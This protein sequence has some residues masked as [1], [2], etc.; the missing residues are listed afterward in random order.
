[1]LILLQGLS[2][3][4]AWMLPLFVFGYS[5]SAVPFHGLG[6]GGLL[7]GALWALKLVDLPQ[8]GAPAA[9]LIFLLCTL[10][11]G[12]EKGSSRGNG[13]LSFPMA[14]GAYS[15]FTFSL[16]FSR[17]LILTPLLLLAFGLLSFSS[18]IFP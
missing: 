18:V 16:F 1:M 10:V 8:L 3:A 5:P 11:L 9:L 13:V 15:L 7:A 4:T 12:L 6:A 17:G 2:A 14:M